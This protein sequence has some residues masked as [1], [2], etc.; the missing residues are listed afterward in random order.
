M[1]RGSSSVSPWTGRR[2]CPAVRKV[3]RTSA[4][5]MSIE[6]D[7]ISARGTMTS[8]TLISCRP[9]TFL[10]MA[11]SCGLK[12]SAIEA[13]SSAS[14]ISSRIEAPL[15]PNK[16]RNRSI[17]EPPCFPGLRSPEA[18]SSVSRS[19]ALIADRLFTWVLAIGVVD[20]QSSQDADF[21]CLHR[22]GFFVVFVV[23]A[24][25][26]EEAVNNH[27]TAMLFQCFALLL[28]L[29]RHGLVGY[30]DIA[31]KTCGFE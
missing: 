8:L 14:S 30:R 13:S 3:P 26:M 12:S 29:A 5:D 21:H 22:L 1:P 7:M 19:G 28:R 11:R 4:S 15:K 24:Q 23:V 20:A 9:S 17:T 10:S 18:V 31:K 6:T 2:E 25:K 27:V 16:E